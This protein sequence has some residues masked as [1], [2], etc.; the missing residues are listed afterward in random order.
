MATSTLVQFISAGEKASTS[1]RSQEET[2]L[3]GGAIA[4]GDWVALD[5]SQTGANKALYVKE[6]TAAAG[7]AVVCGVALVAAA[8]GAQVRVC[9]G[10]F[11]KTASVVNT[12]AAGSPLMTSGATAGMAIAATYIGN[13]SGAVAVALPIP[14][15]VA[16]TAAGV[17]NT[18][19]VWVTSRF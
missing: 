5:V 19:E 7:S 6:T 11:C 15:G 4:A 18:A 1:N 8:T 10:G 14:C 13:G 9:I 3:A 17:S 12:T 16:L 2:F